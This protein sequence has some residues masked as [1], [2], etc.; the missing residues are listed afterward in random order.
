MKKYKKEEKYNKK[1]FEI[2]AKKHLNIVI[3]NRG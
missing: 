2:Y 3:M 1:Y